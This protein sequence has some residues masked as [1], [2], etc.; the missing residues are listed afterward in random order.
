MLTETGVYV[1]GS[2][3]GRGNK[4]REGRQIDGERKKEKQEKEKIKGREVGGGEGREKIGHI[5]ISLD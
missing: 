5:G 3:K 2:A 4:K 1:R